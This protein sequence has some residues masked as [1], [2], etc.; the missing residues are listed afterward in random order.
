MLMAVSRRNRPIE[1]PGIG[2]RTNRRHL[3]EN[4]YP[5]SGADRIEIVIDR[6]G[7]FPVGSDPTVP[8]PGLVHTQIETC[9]P[10]LVSRIVSPPRLG[11]PVNQAR[12][13]TTH[14]DRGWHR[15]HLRTER[16]RSIRRLIGLPTKGHRRCDQQQQ[17][18]PP[19]DS[20]PDR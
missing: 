8:I 2:R 10:R 6:Y 3:P 19:A 4:L 17:T 16:G 11:R 14:H 12:D 1:H 9:L 5:I 7:Q 13:A 15:L 18:A 20:R